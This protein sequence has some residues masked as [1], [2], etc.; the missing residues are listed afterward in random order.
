[1]VFFLNRELNRELE[2]MRRKSQN[3][4]VFNE[5]EIDVEACYVTRTYMTRHGAGRFDSECDKSEINPDMFDE[6]NVPNP[7]QGTLRYGKIDKM[8]L[9]GRIEKDFQSN[10]QSK[11]KKSLAIT[12]I[13]EYPW[14][15]PHLFGFKRIYMSADMTRSSVTL[16]K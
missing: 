9:L 13:N 1:M 12:H 4:T 8:G 16:W 2:Q 14:G 10:Y 7:H 11:W 6:T 5:D 3:K 15:F